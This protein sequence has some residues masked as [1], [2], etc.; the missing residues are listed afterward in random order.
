MNVCLLIWLSLHPIIQSRRAFCS[1]SKSKMHLEEFI[2]LQKLQ[3][4]ACEV[5]HAG[6]LQHWWI[7]KE[8]SCFLWCWIWTTLIL[9]ESN[10]CCMYFIQICQNILKRNCKFTCCGEFWT[11]LYPII[12]SGLVIWWTC[13][14][15]VCFFCR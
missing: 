8:V 14:F 9:V 5:F 12:I 4:N 11:L 3:H 1:I 15:A 10:C 7:V 6:L 13:Q 2:C